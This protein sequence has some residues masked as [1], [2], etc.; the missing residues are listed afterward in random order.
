MFAKF[1]IT[2]EPP[3]GRGRQQEIL[4][5]L[6][7]DS[8]ELANRLIA[9]PRRRVVVCATLGKVN[10][11]YG[12]IACIPTDR[13]PAESI[14]RRNRIRRSDQIRFAWRNSINANPRLCIREA[15]Y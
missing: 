2:I 10:P 12:V 8:L 15:G 1:L 4:G 5:A 9:V 7:S 11:T 6:T 14:R 3:K 13:S